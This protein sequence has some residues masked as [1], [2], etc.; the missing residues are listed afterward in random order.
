MPGASW[1]RARRDAAGVK[2]P[3]LSGI[4]L[5]VLN[6]REKEVALFQRGDYD[7][8]DSLPPDYYGLLAK[9]N[10]RAVVDL[11]LSDDDLPAL[12]RP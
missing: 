12:A 8:I 1:L 7:L 4:R 10:P 5:D 3:Y 9:K 2:L 11:A 6:N